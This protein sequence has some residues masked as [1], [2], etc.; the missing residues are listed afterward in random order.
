MA[1][2]RTGNDDCLEQLGLLSIR[3]G[4]VGSEADHA[5]A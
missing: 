3:E 4:D 2:G 5:E 1:V